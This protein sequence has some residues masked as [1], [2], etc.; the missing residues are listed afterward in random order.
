M[1]ERIVCGGSSVYPSKQGTEKDGA[2]ERNKCLRRRKRNWK[3]L[4]CWEE[5]KLPWI[6]LVDEL[7]LFPRWAP[8]N[9]NT[10]ITHRCVMVYIYTAIR[11]FNIL[12]INANKLCYT[13]IDERFTTLAHPWCHGFLLTVSSSVVYFWSWIADVRLLWTKYWAWA[14]LFLLCVNT[15]Y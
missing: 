12:Y 9:V 11:T 7:R 10:I 15:A 4:N 8:H 14:Y 3:W 13:G 2:G 6:P 5:A 1:R